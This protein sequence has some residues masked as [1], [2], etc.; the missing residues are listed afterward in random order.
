MHI[1]HRKCKTR[2]LLF[3]AKDQKITLE[4]HLPA[5]RVEARSCGLLKLIDHNTRSRKEMGL[6]KSLWVTSCL[7]TKFLTIVTENSWPNCSHLDAI[8]MPDFCVVLLPTNSTSKSCSQTRA[9]AKL[10]NWPKRDK[11]CLIFC[12][13]FFKCFLF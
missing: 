11:V 8:W 9:L 3:Q 12:G 13:F 1:Y 7:R 10:K 6:W 2:A 5:A 4:I